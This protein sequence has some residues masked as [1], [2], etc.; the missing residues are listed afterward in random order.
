MSYLSHPFFIT[1]RNIGR[2]LGI[3]SLLARLLINKKYEDAFDR[4]LNSRINNGDIIWDVGANVGY[5]SQK[6]ANLIGTSGYVYAFEPSPQNLQSLHKVVDILPNGKV[7]PFALG[8]SEQTVQFK[9]GA[10]DLGATSSIVD[11]KNNET[12]I[13]VKMYPADWVISSGLVPS[14]NVI[15][16]DVEGYEYEVLQGLNKTLHSPSLHTIGIEIHFGL[17]SNRSLNFAPKSIE[18]QLKSAGF[19]LL[20]PDSSHIIAYRKS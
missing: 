16:I 5:Y 1:L 20:W 2:T 13:E 10:D 8:D 17:L 6:F 9:Q 11:G 3:N 15:K 4:E 12:T 19:T 7:L 14:P 18:T